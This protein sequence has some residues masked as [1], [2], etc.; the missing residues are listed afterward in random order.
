V[1]SSFELYL[2]TTRFK[3]RGRPRNRWQDEVREDG[4]MVGG[5]EWQE[6]V[7]DREEWKKLRRTA[8]NR[9]ILHMPME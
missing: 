9:R 4:R 1:V 8:R 6:K 7:Y 5:E 3:P 2:V